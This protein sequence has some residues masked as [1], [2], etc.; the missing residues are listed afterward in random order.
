M[1]T[2]FRKTFLPRAV[3]LTT[4]S[5]FTY[6]ILPAFFTRSAH[7]SL[8]KPLIIFYLVN[9]AIILYFFRKWLVGGYEISSKRQSLRE[10][11]NL[12]EV[13]HAKESRVNCGLKEKD[14]RYSSLERILEEV[15]LS[16]DLDMIAQVLT[17]QV[18]TLIGKGKGVCS[19]FLIDSFTQKPVLFKSQKEDSK[20]VIK[21]KEG[22]L[23]DLWVLKHGS[24][25]LV[26]DLNN[27]FRF[28][29]DKLL[30]RE[31]RGVASVAS[32]PLLSENRQ[33]GI[34][35]QDSAIPRAYLEDD[36]R[37]LAAI[38]DLGSISI[39]NSE[40]FK[41]AQD[42]ATH[43]SL[44]GLYTKSYF[45][46]RLEE[47]CKRG[48]ENDSCL[49]LM[50]LDIDFFKDYNDR[51]GHTIGDIVLKQ[52]GCLISNSF[53]QLK[54]L[55]SRFGGEEF[56]VAVSA[57]EKK[58]ALGLAE[59]LRCK[60]ES[61]KVILRRT[62]TNIT[63]SIGLAGFPQDATDAQELVRKADKAMYEAK[64]KGRNRVCSI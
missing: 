8:L 15:N 13:E 51:F 4:A 57:V 10:S 34:L 28:D 50:M 1:P 56:C 30:S 49:C 44:T 12:L 33:L 59:A 22:N 41:R 36:L 39:E 20:V 54:S 27:D 35:R 2:T 61:E 40:L 21:D 48:A 47:E 58:Y 18:F 14:F 53:P 17:S 16:L 64:Q 52:V 38:A 25:L 31:E 19:L 6:F 29:P 45:M 43:D 63:V 60:I 62:P 11:I 24:P 46:E 42:L 32:A 5:I 7:I 23:L 9:L 26:E 37:F 3:I 55:F